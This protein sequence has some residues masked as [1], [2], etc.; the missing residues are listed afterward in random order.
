MARPYISQ[1]DSVRCP[2]ESQG[3]KVFSKSLLWKTAEIDLLHQFILSYRNGRITII[4]ILNGIC[5][6]N[7]LVGCRDWRYMAYQH[8]KLVAS[9]ISRSRNKQLPTFQWA[10]KLLIIY[11]YPPS[12]FCR[13][14]RR[15]P[16]SRDPNKPCSDELAEGFSSV[17][18]VRWSIT[19]GSGYLNLLL[20]DDILCRRG[21][22]LQR[23]RRSRNSDATWISVTHDP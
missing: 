1:F 2:E 12:G 16:V 5:F 7:T 14:F 20:A 11:R 22:V 21:P 19:V 13:V 23:I 4:I 17:L 6:R 8:I 15:E 3:W 18:L 10:I 9:W